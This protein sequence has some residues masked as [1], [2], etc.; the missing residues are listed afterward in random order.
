MNYTHKMGV[1]STGWQRQ[2]RM[3]KPRNLRTVGDKRDRAGPC[4][5]CRMKS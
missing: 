2:E 4:E 1:L 5:G 3:L